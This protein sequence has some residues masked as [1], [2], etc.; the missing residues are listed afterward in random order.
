MSTEAP[1]TAVLQNWRQISLI[2][3]RLNSFR[4]LHE[5]G[6]GP[7]DTELARLLRAL[8]LYKVYYESIHSP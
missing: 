1:K 8:Q 5:A 4:I 7:E 2:T 6:I 3:T